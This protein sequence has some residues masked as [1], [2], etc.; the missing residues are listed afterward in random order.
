MLYEIEDIA[1]EKPK[2]NTFGQSM[3]NLTKVKVGEGKVNVT[4]STFTILS[5]C[6]STN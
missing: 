1:D 2:R 3:H 5:H 4:A 6:I